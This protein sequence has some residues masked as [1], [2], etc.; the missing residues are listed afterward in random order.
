[1]IG[2]LFGLWTV[3]SIR[4]CQLNECCLFEIL[5][6]ANPSPQ[7]ILLQ[8]QQLILQIAIP[9]SPPHTLSPPSSSPPPPPAPLPPPPEA[10]PAPPLHPPPPPPQSNPT[11]P[12]PPPPPSHLAPPLEKPTS[13]F[14]PLIGQLA[15]AAGLAAIAA[16]GIKINVNLTPVRVDTLHIGL[17]TW[18]PQRKVREFITKINI[19]GE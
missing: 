4:T 9:V 11:P 8:Q 13:S 1:M 12:P 18:A 15:I 17:V 5:R 3:S 7:L 16:T 14:I 2:C 6:Q 19:V 10:N